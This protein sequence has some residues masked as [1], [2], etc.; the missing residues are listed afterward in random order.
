ML[1]PAAA[2]TPAGIRITR[3]RMG[4][5]RSTVPGILAIQAVQPGRQKKMNGAAHFNR[6]QGSREGLPGCPDSP[7]R[8]PG[9]RAME[10]ILEV[11]G[12]RICVS[13]SILLLKSSLKQ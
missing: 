3:E 2:E 13:I 7:H 4:T 5:A 9:F 11:R 10:E 6:K 1:R 8:V 12:S